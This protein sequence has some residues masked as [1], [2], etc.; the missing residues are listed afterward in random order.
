MEKG[1]VV[2]VYCE[3][4]MNT[5]GCEAPPVLTGPKTVLTTQSEPVELA[6][7]SP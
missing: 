3:V 4:A 2:M 1:G 6:E 5:S 7:Q